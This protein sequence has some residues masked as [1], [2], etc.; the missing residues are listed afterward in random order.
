MEINELYLMTAFVCSACDGEIANEEV[1]L[2]KTF[3]SNTSLFN[4]V[5]VERMLNEYVAQINQEGIKFINNFLSHLGKN[6][7][8]EDVQMNIVDIA[9]KM[10]EADNQVLYSEVKF[11][12][13][14]RSYLTI[15]DEKIL[16]K[17]PDKED[18]LLPDNRTTEFEFS[19]DNNFAPI[20]LS[21][22]KFEERTE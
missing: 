5:D 3:C 20:N 22:L 13:K 19:F 18:Y 10:I 7:F 2:I 8:P 11:F 21:A 6:E 9:I 16:E 4:G 17:M 15:S 14:L 12:K 1:D